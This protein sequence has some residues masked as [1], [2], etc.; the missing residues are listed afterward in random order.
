MNRLVSR[1]PPE[2]PPDATAAAWDP[3]R[4]IAN[5][6]KA[7][8]RTTAEVIHTEL[9]AGA[10]VRRYCV[11]LTEASAHLPLAWSWFGP[12]DT[13]AIHPQ[14]YAGRAS[15]WG[16]QLVIERNW[17]TAKGPSFG[18]LAGRRSAPF[19]IS[20]LA[21]WGPWR[22]AAREHGIRSVLCLPLRAVGDQQSGVFVVYADRSDYFDAAMV[23]FFESISDMFGAILAR[24]STNRAL[25]LAV[26]TDALTGLGNRH[27]LE[28]LTREIG[29]YQPQH[30]PPTV[31]A[32]IDLDHFKAVND[33]HGH[34][35]GDR[36]LKNAAAALREAV[37]LSD[38]VLRFGGEEF[39]LC[40]RGTSLERGVA[41][42]QSACDAMRRVP[43]RLSD[44]QI[45]QVTCSIGVAQLAVD[46]S[47][48]EAIQRAD[49]ALY[50]A[51][52]AGRDRVCVA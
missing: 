45:L 17:L 6:S 49:V 52:Q 46:E 22:V 13:A 16:E 7:L 25:R 2:M 30:Q 48:T 47:L 21:P 50:A 36:V 51:K 44:G 43:H 40:L 27:A 38:E 14:V 29:R 12:S 35:A 24:A 1:R 3:R 5:L 19:T 9:E 32:L 42:A 18:A 33:T 4:E 31:V 39:L 28:A 26:M 11:A 8:L 23:E 41:I 34:E 20:R 37:R 10:V 15:A